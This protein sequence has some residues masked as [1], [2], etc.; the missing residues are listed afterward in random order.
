MPAARS[1]GKITDLNTSEDL[2]L[3]H[4]AMPFSANSSSPAESHID[5]NV[6][7]AVK[8]FLTATSTV[9]SHS[10]FSRVK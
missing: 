7:V 3:W 9:K 4:S 10:S 1:S 2:A 8:P 6:P 5:T